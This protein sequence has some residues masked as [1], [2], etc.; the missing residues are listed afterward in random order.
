MQILG[1]AQFSDFAPFGVKRLGNCYMELSADSFSSTI[2]VEEEEDYI[3][4]KNEKE[5]KT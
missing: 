3:F 4:S 5:L 2:L 1:L